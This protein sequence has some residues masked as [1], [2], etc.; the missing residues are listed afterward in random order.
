[1]SVRPVLKMGH[2][3]LFRVSAPV[4]EINSSET[5]R[6]IKDLWDTALHLQGAG[7]AAPQIGCSQRVI[8]FGVETP[9]Y[10]PESKVPTTLLINPEVEVLDDTQEYGMEG[11]LSVPGLRG[12]VP[13]FAR[14]RYS[15]YDPDGH[16]IERE[17][18][19]FHARV[20]QHECDHLDGL[21][22]PQRM[23]DMSQ[24]RFEDAEKVKELSEGDVQLEVSTE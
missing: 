17:A 22:F 21:L 11:C 15:G 7:I 4:G 19:G 6:L 1:M 8:L 12:L 10:T 5:R 9:R 23:Q 20:V 18:T 13:R 14:I 3:C 16:R 2:P 24:L